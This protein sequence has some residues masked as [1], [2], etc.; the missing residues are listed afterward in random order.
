TRISSLAG[1]RYEVEVRRISELIYGF[2]SQQ[3]TSRTEGEISEKI[4]GK[5]SYKVSALRKLC[6]IDKRILREGSGHK[7]DPYK[8]SCTLVPAIS[9]EQ[10]NKILL[11]DMENGGNN[12]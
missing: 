6:F 10:E 3:N 4:E 1:S 12:E 8:Y 11:T 9:K 5:N 7:G 2:L